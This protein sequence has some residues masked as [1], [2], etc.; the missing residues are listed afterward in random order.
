MTDNEIVKALE[1]C[2]QF[3]N[4][5][6]FNGNGDEKCVQALQMM[7]VIKQA[8]N[9]FNSQKAEIERLK[10]IESNILNVMRENIAQTQAEAIKEFADI[11][12]QKTIAMVYSPDEVTT[13]DYIAVI[14][15]VVKE[16]GGDACDR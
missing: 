3:E 16:L 5:I 6:V 8:L 2:N 13:D 4:N 9:E 7:V 11:V 12:K 15:S 14:D 1:W 10:K